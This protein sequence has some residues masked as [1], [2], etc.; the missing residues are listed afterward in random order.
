MK[1][2]ITIVMVA[3][4]MLEVRGKCAE[5]PTA[6]LLF[7]SETRLLGGVVVYGGM[8]GGVRIFLLHDPETWNVNGAGL[9]LARM[10]C[11]LGMEDVGQ[12]EDQ[13]FGR[14]PGIAVDV[15]STGDNQAVN[16][17]SV[18]CDVGD[19]PGCE[20]IVSCCND[21]RSIALP[22]EDERYIS[23]NAA[24]LLVLALETAQYA[25]G[26]FEE[27]FSVLRDE[28]PFG[29]QIRVVSRQ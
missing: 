4:L 13:Y 9:D 28:H 2:F 10:M 3:C 24:H 25:P 7:G 15:Y 11:D 17:F 21:W 27:E 8:I 20:V 1:R 18:R 12:A 16:T 26:Y 23:Y 5:T 29:V 6:D 14:A 22:G 19:E